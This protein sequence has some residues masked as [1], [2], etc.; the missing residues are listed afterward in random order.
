MPRS[1]SLVL[2]LVG[3]LV[4]AFVVTPTRAHAAVAVRQNVYALSGPQ[5]KTLAKGVAAMKLKKAS[6]PTSWA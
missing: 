6:D 3:S 1:S 5:L 4:A 2:P